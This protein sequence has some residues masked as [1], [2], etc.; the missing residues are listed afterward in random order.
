M[1]VVFLKFAAPIL[2]PIAISFFLTIIGAPAVEKLVKIKIPRIV[3]AGI[4]TILMVLTIFILISVMNEAIIE[5]RNNMPQY[6]ISIKN[7]V[8]KLKVWLEKRGIHTEELE[9]IPLLPTD[10]FASFIGSII[11]GAATI[12]TFLTLVF[13]TTFFM[14]LETPKWKTKIGGDLSH[15]IFKNVSS[16]IQTFLLYK[17]GIS[18]VTGFIIGISLYLFDVQFAVLWG[19]IAFILNYIPNVGS[20]I[21]SIPAIAFTLLDNGL[22]T[23]ILVTVVYILVNF[24]IGNIIEPHLVGR[25]FALSPAVIII[26]LMLWSW[27]WGVGG[28]FI[29]T[30]LMITIKSILKNSSYSYLT[31]FIE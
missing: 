27:I 16:E 12:V 3:A 6:N 14:L 21:A 9:L 17:T 7:S 11:K 26:S 20:I 13:I 29:A 28:M 10:L 2:L 22:K 15:N 4:V 25:E 5:I 30:P 8:E 1:L 24:I 18:L 19:T 23:A 31:R